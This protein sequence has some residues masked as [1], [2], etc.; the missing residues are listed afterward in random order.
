LALVRNCCA[1]A[2]SA[3]AVSGRVRLIVVQQRNT[4]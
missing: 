1:A 4:R 2:Y 3:R